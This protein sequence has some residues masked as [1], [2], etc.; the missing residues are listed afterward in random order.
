MMLDKLHDEMVVIYQETP[1]EVV[2]ATI[3]GEWQEIGAGN[4]QK[5]FNNDESS[6]TKSSLVRDIFGGL[7]RT[8]FHVE[9]RKHVTV[10]FEPFFLLNLEISRCEDLESCLSSFF[11]TKPLTD[12]MVDGKLARAWHQQQIESLPTILI[13]QL[14]RF[15][16]R[17]RPIKMKEDIYFPEVL[18]I[19][20]RYV[21]N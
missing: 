14:K 21:S 7:L 3:T 6:L 10:S 18:R 1:K 13:L 19:E 5:K 12:Y 2:A 4:Q 8:E 9:G 20:D 16:Y 15:V 17:D 11:E